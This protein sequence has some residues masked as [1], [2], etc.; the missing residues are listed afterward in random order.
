MWPSVRQAHMSLV[1]TVTVLLGLLS[2]PSIGGWLSEYHGWPS[3][4]YI[5]L[6]IAAYIF[7]KME[8][9]L[10]A[11]QAEQKAPFHFFGMTTLSLVVIGLQMRLDRGER[12]EWFDSPEI[13]A[14]ATISTL[15]FCL[16]LVHVM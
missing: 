2:G 11:K 16:Y 1:W 15:S 13:W 6:P 12:M 10:S 7:L 3:L 14:E 9:T 5:S 4:F 8:F